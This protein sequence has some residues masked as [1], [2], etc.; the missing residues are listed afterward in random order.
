[1]PHGGMGLPLRRPPS[2][3][4][5]AQLVHVV[6][7]DNVR[8]VGQYLARLNEAGPQL[9]QCLTQLLRS[10]ADNIWGVLSACRK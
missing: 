1:M 10:A 6:L 5:H 7:P 4:Q 2:H 8:P 9:S 3:L